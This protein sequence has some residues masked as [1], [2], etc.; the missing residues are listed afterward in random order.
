MGQNSF[1]PVDWLLLNQWSMLSVKEV[2]ELIGDSTEYS[3]A[4]IEQI[5]DECRILAEL[6][7]ES[8]LKEKKA[9]NKKADS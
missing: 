8:W 6:A 7:F 2:R 1:S 5:R 4:E 3:D 9:E